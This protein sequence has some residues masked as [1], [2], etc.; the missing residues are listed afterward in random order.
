MTLRRACRG[1]MLASMG[2]KGEEA[3]FRTCPL[4]RLLLQW[5][6]PWF[7]AGGRLFGRALRN[8][9]VSGLFPWRGPL[10]RAVG[11]RT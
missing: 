7:R 1:L 11:P 6:R 8:F 3:R 2:V 10:L 4:L 9:T 5:G